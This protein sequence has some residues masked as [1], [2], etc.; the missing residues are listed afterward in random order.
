MGNAP[1]N[2]SQPN[3]LQ[4]FNFS[5]PE[6]ALSHVQAFVDGG[7]DVSAPC[8]DGSGVQDNWNVLHRA[9]AAGVVE[10]VTWVLDHT[11]VNANIKDSEGRTALG[12][13]CHYEHRS[14]AT[15]MVEHDKVE[16]DQDALWEA[17]SR[18]VRG[19]IEGWLNE[20]QNLNVQNPTSGKTL[21]HYA[22]R[23]GAED[24]ALFL[25]KNGIN[26]DLVSKKGLSG[27]DCLYASGMLHA[28]HQLLRD[29][30]KAKSN[31]KLC[32]HFEKT[33]RAQSLPV[34]RK[35]VNLLPVNKFLDAGRLVSYV[36]CKA[37]RERQKLERGS[38]VSE[39]TRILFVSH[40]WESLD[41][42]DPNNLHYLMVKTFLQ[43]RPGRYEY[44]FLDYSCVSPDKSSDEYQQQLN[45]VST[46]IFLST[47]MLMLP[48]NDE[49]GY[50]DVGDLSSRAW[51]RY[52]AMTAILSG[53]RTYLGFSCANGGVFFSKVKVDPEVYFMAVQAAVDHWTLERNASA[54]EQAKIVSKWLP[55]SGY[56][57]L[58]DTLALAMDAL[59]SCS[60]EVGQKI[61]TM[62]LG[63]PEL[64]GRIAK[65]YHNLGG[66]SDSLNDSLSI[67]R[68]LLI[69]LA[70]CVDPGPPG[71]GAGSGDRS[72]GGNL[73]QRPVLSDQ[74]D[75]ADAA[76][77]LHKGDG[78]VS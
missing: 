51:M 66:C 69:T 1:S 78:E 42:P 13:A 32:R 61:L 26:T 53:C 27:L 67:L 70:Y 46:A 72:L 64:G 58:G 65:L 76:S 25:V 34:S 37:G 11:D 7:G 55:A 73:E 16:I 9:C 50:S 3:G 36:D 28:L 74:R 40:R 19:V 4:S 6:E 35:Y 48:R 52:E 43:Q 18:G 45:N 57:E 10:V 41:D 60:E 8:G 54:F 33:M 71:D 17:A 23:G 14:L 62:S 38:K 24:I 59:N 21:L 15:I 47:D 31:F 63:P 22:C 68:L 29:R 56:W 2:G 5:T 30:T 49:E 20:G 39:K 77:V 12:L 75:L 44:I